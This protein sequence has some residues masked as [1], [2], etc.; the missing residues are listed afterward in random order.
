[1]R[2]LCARP[3][4]LLITSLL[5]TS[6]AVFAL[7]CAVCG[8]K[9]SGRY[10][11]AGSN[12]YCSSMC[13]KKTLP[14][15]AA[16]G[17]RCS[18]GYFK[19]AGKV[20]CSESCLKTTLPKCSICGSPFSSGVKIQSPTGTR[21][22]CPQ[23]AKLPRCFCCSLPARCRKLQDGRNIC[24]ACYKNAIFE[25]TEAQKVFDEVRGKMRKDLGIGSNHRIIFK[26]VDAKFLE[27]NSS[28]HQPGQEL[29]LYKHNYTRKTIT[30]TSYSLLGGKKQNSKT[31]S[32]DDRYYIYALYGVPRYKLIEIC[33]HELAHDWMEEQ[34]PHIKD[35]KIK[36]GW[37]E[38]IASAVND[39]FGQSQYNE[40]MN[41]NP[42]PV[43]G[44]GFRFINTYISRHG[45]QALMDYFE[46]LNSKSA[47]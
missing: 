31:F 20:Y 41:N 14:R 16:C 44:E 29:G 38:Y 30:K 34:F 39:L 6:F 25:Q 13:Y 28:N 12:A 11:K 22:Y 35:L 43:Y 42:D 45:A 10:V 1:M 46:R 33:A 37:A 40:R 27:K 3:Y 9:I 8:K 4:A 15:C 21:I 32:T 5:L 24:P 23:C 17:K 2:R 47:K 7:D 19:K 36:E 18:N 26:L